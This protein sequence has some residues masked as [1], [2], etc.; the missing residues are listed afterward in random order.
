MSRPQ[1]PGPIRVLVVDDSGMT[2]WLLREILQR[3]PEITV[4]GEA[5]DA[6][7][8]RELI[9]A[10]DPDVVTLD[11]E[12]PGMDGITFLRNLMRLRPTPVVMVSSRTALGADVSLQALALGAVDC[13]CKPRS[14]VDEKILEAYA[15]ELSTKVRAAS[16]ARLRT[17]VHRPEQPRPE[18]PRQA[19]RPC[20]GAPSGHVVAIGASTGGTE[21]IPQ[22]LERLPVDGPGIVVVQH[23]SRPFDASFARRLDESLPHCVV[24]A[25]DGDVVRRGCVHVAPADRHLRIRRSAGEFRC[26]LSDE[27][28]VGFHRPSVDLLFESL[29]R[30]AGAAATGVLLTGMGRDGASGL[31]MMRHAGA[32]TITQDEATSVVWGMPGAAVELDAAD[33]VAELSRIGRLVEERLGAVSSV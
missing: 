26:E 32:Y 28:P 9:K 21:A 10:L 3:D 2:R 31:A 33:D 4:V 23:I 17:L 18:P 5:A 29:A 11:V 14:V 22:V 27:A 13:V 6:R 20:S 12:M 7:E 25:E 15:G 24:L 30:H 19:P 1:R 8:A 16:M